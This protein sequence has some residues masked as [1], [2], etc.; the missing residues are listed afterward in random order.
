MCH[1]VVKSSPGT[2]LQASYF[3]LYQMFIYDRGS[4]SEK[5]V[6]R[7]SAVEFFVYAGA[8]YTPRIVNQFHIW[9]EIMKSLTKMSR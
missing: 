5:S 1:L 2:C 8:L 4:Y 6:K 3:V 7:K 9:I